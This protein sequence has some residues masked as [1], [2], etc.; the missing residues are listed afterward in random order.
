MMRLFLSIYFFSLTSV[1]E[2]QLWCFTLSLISHQWTFFYSRKSKTNS[3]EA[4]G[5]YPFTKC[6]EV[7]KWSFSFWCTEYSLVLTLQL[8]VGVWS[9]HLAATEL[10]LCE[11]LMHSVQSCK[12][13]K[14]KLWPCN[15]TLTRKFD[16]LLT[17]IV[18]SILL[19]D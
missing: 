19:W 4:G 10:W 17:V 14:I 6:W 11:E 1:A 13:Q 18:A 7:R 12:D 9:W 8:H 16:I 2:W 5:V 15:H 3:R